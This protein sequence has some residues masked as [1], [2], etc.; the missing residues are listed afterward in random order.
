MLLVDDRTGSK[1]YAALIGDQAMITRLESGDIAF[2]GNG[3]TV[4]VEVKKILDAVNCMYSGR[5]AD[6]QIP[7]MKQ[8]YDVCYLIV[9]GIWRPDPESGVLQYYKG[10]LG[11]WG[12]WIDVASGRKRLMASSFELWLS[13]MEN[14]GGLRVR[15]AISP[16]TTASLLMSLYQWWQRDGHRSFAV[17]QEL[18]GDAAVLSRPTMLRRM[19]ALLPHVGWERSK[20]LQQRVGG[21]QFIRKDRKPMEEHDWYIERE[22]AAKSAADI[23][24]ACDGETDS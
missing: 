1:H 12:K 2:E 10:E 15:S 16:E 18:T 22:I 20:D 24:K 3:I 19:L 21:V 13:T 23:E 4:G 5:L 6:Y 14:L 17:M 9:E 8:Q 11:K 7:L